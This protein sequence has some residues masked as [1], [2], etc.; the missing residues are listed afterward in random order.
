MSFVDGLAS[1]LREMN[2][3][4]LALV[5]AAVLSYSL[6]INSSYSSGLR[7]GAASVAFASA[8]GF[9]TLTPAWMSAVV[10]LA[11]AVVAVAA[12]AGLAWALSA[13]LGLGEARPTRTAPDSAA[14]RPALPAPARGFAPNTRAQPL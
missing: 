3:G 4:E 5:L 8:A 2:L 1:V 9:T 12:V 14:V 11:L 7:S 13:V 6:A 10:F